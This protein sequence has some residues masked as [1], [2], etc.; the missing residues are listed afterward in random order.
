MRQ[1][2]ISNVKR[3][4]FN[5]GELLTAI[6]KVN[7]TANNL[8]SYVDTQKKGFFFVDGVK[9]K[10]EPQIN[11]TNCCYNCG[12]LNHRKKNCKKRF[13]CMK[14]SKP[15]HKEEECKSSYEYCYRCQNKS[16]RCDTDRCE[17]LAEKTFE[18]NKYII[19]I[20]IGEQIIDSRFEI[21]KNKIHKI[22]WR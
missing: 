12:D 5:G 17:I 3:Q 15:G 22:F 16:H 18:Q 9:Y 11:H 2:Q 1:E 4:W 19:S 14:C 13:R 21:L 8:K 6:K 7:F 10:A 20:L